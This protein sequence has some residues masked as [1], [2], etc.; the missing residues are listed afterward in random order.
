MVRSFHAFRLTHY[1]YVHKIRFCPLLTLMLGYYN[2]VQC[3]RY[4]CKVR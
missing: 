3:K 2:R 1:L 4:L